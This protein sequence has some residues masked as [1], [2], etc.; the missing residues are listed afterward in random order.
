M[1]VRGARRCYI[2]KASR[3]QASD[4]ATVR[5]SSGRQSLA[6]RI[7]DFLIRSSRLKIIADQVSPKS[8]QNFSP[9]SGAVVNLG[10]FHVLGSL[11]HQAYLSIHLSTD[12]LCLNSVQR[13]L[14]RAKTEGSHVL[15]SQCHP[16]F[17]PADNKLSACS[18][19]G[20]AY[21]GL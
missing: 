12:M 19:G 1:K 15:S 11:L 8:G 17:S 13:T 9:H 5:S 7:G 21:C 18:G 10:S 3:L 4:G 16:R 20:G 14:S 6:H 2:A